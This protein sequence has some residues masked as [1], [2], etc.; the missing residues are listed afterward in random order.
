MNGPT[1]YWRI[2][3]MPKAGTSE[4][5]IS[6]HSEDTRPRR[7]IMISWGIIRICEGIIM[8]MRIKANGAFRPGKR[9]LAKQNAVIEHRKRAATVLTVET[10]RELSRERVKSMTVSREAKLSPR[11]SPGIITGGKRKNSAD[12]R[13]D[14]TNSQ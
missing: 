2:Q 7:P 6:A 12:A 8:V 5:R 1:Q 9:N 14:M 3:K 11:F 10:I 13:V 4:G